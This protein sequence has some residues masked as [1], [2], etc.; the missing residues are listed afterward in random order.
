MMEHFF[1]QLFVEAAPFLTKDGPVNLYDWSANKVSFKINSNCLDSFLSALSSYTCASYSN[2][3]KT[4][5]LQC[6]E[7]RQIILKDDNNELSYTFTENELV[8]L[9]VLLTKAKEKMYGW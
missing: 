6:D 7:N 5:R 4:I 1:G 2:N 3:K 9:K 8:G